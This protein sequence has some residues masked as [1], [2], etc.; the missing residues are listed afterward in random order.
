MKISTKGRYAL[1]AVVDL[2][3]HAKDEL[4][5]LNSIAN[6]LKKSKN[7]LEQLFVLLR[8]NNI[9][10]SIRGSQGGYKLAREAS[11]I[12][13]GDVVRAV[14][15]SLAPVACL[16][17]S[18]E[19]QCCSDYEKCVTRVVWKK[20]MEEISIVLDEVTIQDLSECFDKMNKENN[21]EYYI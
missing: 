21:L 5:S 8:Q 20:M 3:Y 19:K 2:S 10:V 11:K 6:R 12:T 1:E 9:V 18:D 15:G 16:D 14:E 4:E 17:N 7:Y 13:A